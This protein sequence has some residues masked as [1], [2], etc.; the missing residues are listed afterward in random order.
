MLTVIGALLCLGCGGVFISIWM[1]VAPEQI[2]ALPVPMWGWVAA[3]LF[4]AVLM[5]FNRRPGD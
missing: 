4:G 3:S 2:L 5:Y 1:G